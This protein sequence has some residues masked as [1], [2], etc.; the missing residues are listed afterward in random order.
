MKTANLVNLILGQAGAGVLLASCAF[1]G[2]YTAATLEPLRKES[3]PVLIA[4]NECFGHSASVVS[5]PGRPSPLPFTVDHV[6]GVGAKEKVRRVAARPVIAVVADQQFARPLP[7]SD[8]V[9]DNVRAALSFSD[10]E[11]AVTVTQ[12]ALPRPAF[13]GGASLH[14]DKETLT[15]LGK[16][17]RGNRVGIAHSNSVSADGMTIKVGITIQSSVG[18]TLS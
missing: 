1:V 5:V 13:G 12:S 17:G 4:T 14:Q 6:V 3:R 11:L 7:G 16:D 8:E 10:A 18:V 2:G 15:M 9:G